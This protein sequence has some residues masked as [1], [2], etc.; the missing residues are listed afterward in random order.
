MKSLYSAGLGICLVASPFYALAE[1][2][3]IVVTPTGIEQPRGTLNTSVTVIDQD[4]ISK[5]NANS[6]SELLRGQAGLHVTDF[7]GDGSQATIDMRGFGPTA[8]SNT[9]VLLDGR[10]L[11]NSSDTRPPDLSLIN[12]DDIERIEIVQGS[13]GV[14]H[15]NQAVGGVINIIRKQALDDKV[16]ISTRIGSYGATQLSVSGNKALGRN[17][18]TASISGR[19]SDNYRDNNE[20]DIERMSLRAERIHGGQTAY[21]EVESI[22]DDFETPGA[23]LED[24]QDED[25]EQSLD[26][27]ADD[28][29]ETETRMLRLGMDK[30][31][32]DTRALKLDLSFRETDREFIQSFRPASPGSLNT[33]DRETRNFSAIYTVVPTEVSSLISYLI[34]IDH[35]DID[36]E[37]VSIF[38]PQPIDQSINGIF[39]SSQW[40][41]SDSTRLD[42]GARYNDLDAESNDDNFDDNLSAFNLGISRTIDSLKIFARLDQNFRYPTVEEH[43]NV[44]FGDEPGLKTQEG[45]SFEIGAETADTDSR[46][47]VTIYRL[48]LENEIAFDSTGFT[49]LN[50]DET[51]RTGIILEASRKWSESYETRISITSIDA[52]ITDGSF[53]GNN[54]PLVP[55]NIIRIDNSYQYNDMTNVGLEILAVDDQTFGGDFVNGLDELSGYEVVNAHV[56]YKEKN[57]SLG[58]R[59]NNL[60]DEEY[61]E[62]GSQFTDF[63]LFP[64][65]QNFEAF[66]PSPERNFWLSFRY[67]LK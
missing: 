33:Q 40:A 66:F 36:Y 22:N 27:F 25:R 64:V 37:L 16:S 49:N 9:L 30:N 12:I 29:F 20:S 63:S 60:L 39:V 56:S 67:D 47:R 23:L 52:E 8:S 41:L 13:S 19:Q 55:E 45:V 11:N 61:A 51:E 58:F 34:G 62:I 48:D 1:L 26:V 31:L 65:V 14:I 43:T 38:G 50:L 10:R 28:F 17:N 59:I 2:G 4:T 46:F 3:P 18:L 35:E 32:S 15:G 53:E 42:A 5:S 54:I 6:V 57:W 21:I 44:P 7:F 24:E